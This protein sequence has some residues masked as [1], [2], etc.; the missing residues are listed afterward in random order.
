MKIFSLSWLIL[1]ISL[2][3]NGQEWVDLLQDGNSNFY[4]VQ[5]S[6]QNHWGDKGYERGK[7]YKQFKRW[8]HFME[9]RV[10]PTGDRIK[11]EIL[12]EAF[13]NA[14]KDA[15]LNA[16]TNTPWTAVGPTAWENQG[17]NPGLGRINA[18]VVDPQNDQRIYVG[19]PSGGLWR[20]ND[21]GAS[22]EPLTDN[23]PSIGVSGMAIN[24]TNSNEIYIATG[25]GNASD[26][27]SIG[28]LKTSDAGVTWETTGLSHNVSSNIACSKILMHP[29]D[30]LKL[31]AAT[32]DGVYTTSDGGDTWILAQTGNVR[33]LEI[34]SANPDIIYAS[35]K[36][37]YRSV[38]G[39]LSF[40]T[41]TSG[42]PSPF[43]VNRLAIAVTAANPDYVY[44]VAGKETD[45][46]L[47][48]VYR[49]T[50]GGLS[51]EL[52][53]DSPNLL[54]WS[55]GGEGEGGQSWYDLAIAVSPVNQNLVFV[56][57]I[58]VWRSANGGS[59][60]SIRSHWFYPNNIG[61]THADI[62]SL[63]YYGNNLYCGSDGGIFRSSNLGQD[64]TDL[65]EGL[66]I[67][68]YYKIA[69]STTDVNKILTGSQDNGTNLFGEGN[70]Y[71]H[72][73]GGDGNGAVIDYSNDNTMYA[74]YP[75]GEFQVS[76]NSGQSFF[77]V[78]DSIN[79][80]GAWVTPLQQHPTNPYIL[81]AAYE[82][83]WQKNGGDPWAPISE[84][85]ISSTLQT[86]KV[87][88]SDAEVIYTSTFSSIFKTISG[89]ETWQN[90]SSGLPNLFITDIE[91]DGINP[92]KLWV[93]LSG[94]SNGQKLY[95][96]EDGGNTW[97][98]I[99]LNLPNIPVTCITYQTGTDEALYVG[100]DVGVYYK[101]AEA[102]SWSSFNEGLP[103]VIIN[104][105]VLHYGTSQV[106]VGTYGRG[107]WI[108]EFFDPSAIV[109]LSTPLPL[110]A[111]INLFP[112]PA[113][114]E[115]TLQ[116]NLLEARHVDIQMF[117][118]LGRKIMQ[119]E[120]AIL[121]SGKQ[122]IIIQ[123]AELTPGFYTIQMRSGER[124]ST[125]K[126]VIKR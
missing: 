76:F 110:N 19:T 43:S 44:M 104:D 69:V 68:Q 103:N 51:F 47:Q 67:T 7:G 50:D 116:L 27:Y 109:S 36:R 77:D 64:W 94:Y 42:V 119:I 107:V 73:L 59:T 93:S 6:F 30:P 25:D 33:D 57:G 14:R 86:L 106:L 10:Y 29:T 63:D 99:S 114:D 34:N 40:S 120:N 52:R 90:I 11:S 60:W 56:G 15:S 105:I 23:L 91:V 46:G 16:K 45:S 22:W 101:N 65:S 95:K 85:P 38:D 49:S 20:S 87:A 66:Q 121:P 24:P 97:E 5:E 117:D 89:G 61:Y 54:T 3:V 9:P 71:V 118:V 62:H 111:D 55:E 124:Q 125:V 88:P 78:T 108:N 58:N 21:N 83:V 28:V 53:S 37:F 100:T 41:I 2:T 70:S 115:V 17:W 1:L 39:G 31:W 98:N 102:I 123:T 79:E 32:T 112:N 75:N 48:G 122:D 113:N 18:I 35:G 92:Q 80:T 74:C 26:T 72:L 4:D 8:E 84:L 96:S 13:K 126:M 82:N 12:I 81:Y